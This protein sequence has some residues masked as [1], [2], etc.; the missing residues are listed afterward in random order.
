MNRHVR[1]GIWRVRVFALGLLAILLIAQRIGKGA[2]HYSITGRVR[3]RT[4]APL[5][6]RIGAGERYE[7]VE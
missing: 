6:W 4:T 2:E 3:E 5:A 1:K 7:E